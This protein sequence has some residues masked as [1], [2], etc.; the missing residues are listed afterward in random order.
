MTFAELRVLSF[1][2]CLQALSILAAGQA[3]GAPQVAEEQL[4][5][6]SEPEQSEDI[7]F[8]NGSFVAVPIPFSNPA[9]GTGLTFGAGYLFRTAP[10]SDKSYLGG[11]YIRSDNGSEGYGVGGS[12]DFVGDLNFSFV[13]ASLGLNYDLTIRGVPIPIEQDG[14]LFSGTL[15]YDVTETNT[16]GLN[17]RFLR[18]DIGLA[19]ISGEPPPE[20]LPDTDLNLGSFGLGYEYDLRDDSDYP[21][22]GVLL[23]V[24]ANYGFDFDDTS[25][26]YIYSSA[27]FDVYRSL[28]SESVIGGRA[29]ACATSRDAPFFD[30][31]SI[32]LI[33]N[34]RGFKP[35][36]Y[37]D[38]SLL[39]FQAEFRQRIGSRFGVVAFGGIGWTGS[40]FASMTDNGE[41]IAGGVGVRYRV[42]K[43]FPVDLSVDFSTNNEDDQFVYVYVGQRF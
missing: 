5:D 9:I 8:S 2:A 1:A 24:D 17:Y 18:S 36:Q 26:N 20:L 32:G 10:E 41:R 12:L 4:L 14:D 7:G 37:Y 28:A 29:T 31:C 13:L 33:D 19:S 23:G 3:L 43:Q 30:K 11:A 27:K 42:T 39:S 16:F 6:V 21:T 35:L 15:G 25:R 40:S 34:F 38:T 22:D